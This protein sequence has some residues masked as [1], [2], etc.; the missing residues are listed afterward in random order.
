MS[1]QSTDK[2]LTDNLKLDVNTEE[3]LREL[4]NRHSGIFL[5]IVTSYVPKNSASG[6]RDDL[7]NDLEYYVYNA[8]LKYDHTKNTKFSTFL[9]N[10]AK[11]ACLNQYNKN[12]KYLITDT[13]ESR[14]TYENNLMEQEKPFVNEWTLDKI[15][16]IIDHHPDERVQQIFH[17]RYIDPQ[18]NKLT[19]WKKVSKELNMSIQGCINIHNSAIKVIRKELKNNYEFDI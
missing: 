14:F 11:W 10:E 8:G 5:D 7:I 1:D 4:V 6:S 9:G 19:P 16:N 12:K 13:D 15:F 18:Y 17:L 2:E 3:S